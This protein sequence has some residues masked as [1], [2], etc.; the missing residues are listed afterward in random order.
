MNISSL[1]DHPTIQSAGS[2]LAVL[3]S[4]RVQ[5]C[6]FARIRLGVGDKFA[7]NHNP[8][9]MLGELGEQ[10]VIERTSCTESLKAEKHSKPHA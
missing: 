4:T 3:T 9:G 5:S 2:Q 6:G 7:E 1:G 10:T 8:R